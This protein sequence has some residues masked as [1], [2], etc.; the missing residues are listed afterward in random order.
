VIH[1]PLVD[2]A[3]SPDA[4]LAG[5]PS[6]LVVG[7]PLFA[8]FD[9]QGTPVSIRDGPAAVTEPR[10]PPFSNRHC[11]NARPAGRGE[12]AEAASSEVRRPTNANG[13][14]QATRGTGERSA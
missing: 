7:R 1:S 10:T 14:A 9:K 13:I 6:A 8:A 2:F 3:R 5:L 12:K 4:G 11:R